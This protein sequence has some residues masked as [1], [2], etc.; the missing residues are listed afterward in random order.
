MRML[1]GRKT[2]CRKRSR[3]SLRAW[4]EFDV[5]SALVLLCLKQ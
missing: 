5:V 1:C 3:S 2:G 4:L